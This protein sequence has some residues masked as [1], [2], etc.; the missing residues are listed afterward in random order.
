MKWNEFQSL[1]IGQNKADVANLMY[2][3][4]AVV[5]NPEVCHI[6]EEEIAGNKYTVARTP[7]LRKLFW[8]E[9][10]RRWI[11]P[12]Q[13]NPAS[14]FQRK[15]AV[16]KKLG[17]L[18]V[19]A[20]DDGLIEIRDLLLNASPLTVTRARMLLSEELDQ[21]GRPDFDWV[22]LVTVEPMRTDEIR[23]W[24]EACEELVHDEAEAA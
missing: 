13:V 6:E 1:L 4:L 5:H 15:L 2:N 7:Q 3:R 12:R 22:G 23:E 19:M 24:E 20:L 21:R 17:I 9:R 11:T 18:A 14:A 16:E 8:E 10:V